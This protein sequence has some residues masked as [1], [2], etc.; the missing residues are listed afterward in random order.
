MYLPLQAL[1][2]QL[3]ACECN[4]QNQD[5]IQN[6]SYGY[7]ARPGRRARSR[8][9]CRGPAQWHDSDS[10]QFPGFSNLPV[11]DSK[12]GCI[13]QVAAAVIAALSPDDTEETF[14]DHR[15]AG[16]TVRSL[17]SPAGRG[18][19]P[20][21]RW[22]GAAGSGPTRPPQRPCTQL[23][24]RRRPNLTT[25]EPSPAAELPKIHSTF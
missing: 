2:L 25:T 21:R 18:P 7:A 15:I 19:A 16:S 23:G 6:V 1:D 5:E 14:S 12:F 17:L 24:S 11:A 8:G 9:S 3:Q 20:G 4:L 13:S 22:P 10:R